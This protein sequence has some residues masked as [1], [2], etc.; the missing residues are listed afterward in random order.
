MES[1]DRWFGD[2]SGP[3]KQKLTLAVFPSF[4]TTMNHQVAGFLDAGIQQ[5]CK[6]AQ[7]IRS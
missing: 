7:G 5:S 1:Q 2:S 4:L 6:S 3:A